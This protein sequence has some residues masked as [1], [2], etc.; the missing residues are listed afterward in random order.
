M[1]DTGDFPGGY[2][3]ASPPFVGREA[4]LTILHDAYQQAVHDHGC[5][6]LVS[7]EAGNGRN[8]RL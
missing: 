6:V 5:I 7:G 3:A 1:T 4:D 2:E 8:W